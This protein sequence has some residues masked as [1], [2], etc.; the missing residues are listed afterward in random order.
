MTKPQYD[1]IPHKDRA[2]WLALRRS[3]IGAS[4]IPA[5]MGTSPWSTPRQIWLSKVEDVPDTDPTEDMAWGI[6][7]EH[8]ILDEVEER[9]GMDLT[10][11]LLVRNTE[12]PWMMASPDG[13]GDGQVVEAKK[14]D[15]WSWDEVP[16]HYVMQVQW[17]LATLGYDKGWVAALH[18]GK[19][20][21]LYEVER[22]E[23]L[24]ALMIEAGAAFW[25]LV[26]S[27]EPPPV[28]AADDPFMA[29]LYPQHVEKA[30]EIPVS[31]A[32]ELRAAK[33]G[34]KAAKERLGLVKAQIKD[35]LQDADT[36]VVGDEIV[37]TWRTQS[38]GEYTVKASESRVFRIN[39]GDDDESV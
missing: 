33:A 25:S 36:A 22:D 19:R 14:V 3:G 21:K 37:A 8:L 7:M 31:L 35:M 34:E 32:V 5:V 15:G 1:I 9:L 39:K 10:R 24:I 29:D 26:E 20:L 2:E 11:G 6:K 28:E 13:I 17:Q 16:E 23:A 4:D 30:V 12:R 27:G 18:R 38:K